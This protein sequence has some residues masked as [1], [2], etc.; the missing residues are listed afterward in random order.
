VLSKFRS[1]SL[2]HCA[3]CAENFIGTPRRESYAPLWGEGQRPNS[4]ELEP[5]DALLRQGLI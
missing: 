4:S 2:W 5:L 3:D 1:Q